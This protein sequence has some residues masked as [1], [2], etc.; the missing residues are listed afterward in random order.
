MPSC[1]HL[2]YAGFSVGDRLLPAYDAFLA[3]DRLFSM[4]DARIKVPNSYGTF[5]LGF[6]PIAATCLVITSLCILILTLVMVGNLLMKMVIIM[7][8]SVSEIVKTSKVSA[9][10][11]VPPTLCC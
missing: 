4:G 9:I 3:V 1:S 10:Y 8:G 7:L 6:C 5:V 11:T 2:F